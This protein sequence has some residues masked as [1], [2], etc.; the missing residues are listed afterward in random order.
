V[1]LYPLSWTQTWGLAL[2]MI[3]GALAFVAAAVA[4][5]R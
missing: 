3:G 5:T 2:L 1:F 4:L